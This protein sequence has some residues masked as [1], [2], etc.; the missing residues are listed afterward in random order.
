MKNTNEQNK[1]EEKQNIKQKK[2]NTKPKKDGKENIIIEIK[3]GLTKK[4]KND[5]GEIKTKKCKGSCGE[6]KLLEEFHICNRN[7][8]DGR[9]D[10][11]KKC[12]NKP[13]SEKKELPKGYKKCIGGK[14]QCN[15]IKLLLEFPKNKEMPDG[16][17]RQCKECRN[18][19]QKQYYEKNKDNPEFKLKVK[20]QNK[21][22]RENN[23]GKIKEW[24]RLW[25]KKNKNHVKKYNIEWNKKNPDYY[26]KHREKELD[27]SKRW[28]KD[29]PEYHK[30]YKKQKRKNDPIYKLK[31][32]MRNM[33]NTTLKLI[34]TK[35]EKKTIDYLG[36]SPEK[37]MIRL[38]FNFTDGMNWKNYGK[39]EIDH[40][41]SIS[42]FIK[43]RITDPKI[44]NALCNLQPLWKT[45]REINGVI[46]VGNAN[47][48][49]N[50]MR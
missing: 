33:V 10:I 32:S 18:K 40:I 44:I 20:K 2:K 7:K 26:D 21:K 13:K 14:I 8:R 42:Y 3:R 22:W 41:I 5:T 25:N 19:Q 9:Q 23:K 49:N 37:L 39:W 46:Y 29:N 28:R 1:W 34:G 4:I 27:R 31:D 24:K 38:E 47:K 45:T 6:I 43:K 48:S 17:I 12:R 11:C 50:L 15:K 30:I 16:H 35:K 36:Y